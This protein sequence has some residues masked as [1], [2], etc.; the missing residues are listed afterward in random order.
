LLEG[1]RTKR[2]GRDM[3]CPYI[4]VI[5]D[6]CGVS[7]CSDTRLVSSQQQHV[8]HVDSIQKGNNEDDD[9]IDLDDDDDDDENDDGDENEGKREENI[10]IDSTKRVQKGEDEL[11]MN[12]P[13]KMNP[14]QKRLFNLKMKLNQSRRLNRTEVLAEGARLGSME[15]MLAEKK[16]MKAIDRKARKADWQDLNKKIGGKV[17]DSHLFELSST[18][19]AKFL[20]KEEQ[21]IA[22]RY[23]V[24]DMYNPGG[25]HRSYQRDL[26][27]LSKG[28]TGRKSHDIYDPLT[29]NDNDANATSSEGARI[30]G[31]ELRGRADKKKKRDVEIEGDVD[32]I[33]KR[34]KRFNQ[35][36]ERNYGK[37]TAEIKQNLERGTAL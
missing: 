18:S 34:N 13:E 16:K 11:I 33:N 4:N 6:E 36:I 27:S 5:I 30:L 26:K 15:V 14:L 22:N 20:K 25:H 21:A 24:N 7:E 1:V 31:E 29:T 19:Q 12:P 17:G 35:K 10:A 8:D 23:E 9:E 28:V 32:Y 3:D 2:R 37:Y